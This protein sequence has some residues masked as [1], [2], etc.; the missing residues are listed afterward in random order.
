MLQLQEQ[1]AAAIRQIEETYETERQLAK[2]NNSQAQEDEHLP[3][4]LGLPG[5]LNGLGSEVDDADADGVVGPGIHWGKVGGRSDGE[6]FE[7][8]GGV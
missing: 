6:I 4:A 1:E 8:H 5:E 7:V 3:F 2:Q